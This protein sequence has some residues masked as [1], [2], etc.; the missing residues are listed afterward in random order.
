MQRHVKN[1]VEKM[2]FDYPKIDGYINKRRNEIKNPFVEDRDENVGGGKSNKITKAIENYVITVDEDK[3][4]QSLKQQKESIN[5]A[6]TV[7][8]PDISMVFK[9]Y[10]F[11]NE[12][13]YKTLQGLATE[14]HV[15]KS[16]LYKERDMFFKDILKSMDLY[17][18]CKRI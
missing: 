1:L 17:Y 11:N 4:L 16:L 5:E 10:Y 8:N 9:R 3:T 18:L 2:L 15:S 14:Y 7:L 13:R 12:A 6:L